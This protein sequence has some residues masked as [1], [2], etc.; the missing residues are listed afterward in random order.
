MLADRVKVVLVL[1]PLGLVVFYIGGLLYLA[2]MALV[3][4][5]ASFEYARLFRAGGFYPAS[6]LVVASTVALAVS[7]AWTGFENTPWVLTLIVCISMAYHLVQYER[8]REQAGTDFAITL[9][10][11]LYFGWLGAY[12]ILLRQLPDGFW[13]LLLTLGCVWIGDSGAYFF[14]RRFGRHALSPRLSPKKT[15]E[16][17]FAEILTAVLGGLLLVLI[18]RALPW[19]EGEMALWHGAMIGL[20]VAAITPLGDLGESMVK[21]QM[22]QKDS[23][24]LLPGHGGAWDRIDSW[25]WAAA[26]GYY[27]ITELFTRL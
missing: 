1:L 21:R 18:F 3:L 25:L 22:G 2:V 9:S 17:Y 24:S 16:G 23:G 5:L 26:I 20:T 7:R 4:A 12:L 6:F 11:A 19:F 27:L 8:G 13:W 15:W 14:G 10:G